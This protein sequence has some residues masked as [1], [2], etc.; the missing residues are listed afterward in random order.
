MTD[1][2]NN[3]VYRGSHV[4]MTHLHISFDDHISNRVITKDMPVSSKH[5]YTRPTLSSCCYVILL[6][7]VNCARATAFVFF[8][9]F[10]SLNLKLY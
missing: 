5:D 1:A 6:R 4:E 3:N 2:T 10:M 9:N 8:F 7:N